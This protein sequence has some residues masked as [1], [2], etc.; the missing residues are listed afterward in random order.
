MTPGD[1][2]KDAAVLAE[3]KEWSAAA[4]ALLKSGDAIPV[5]DK[6]AFYLSR[7]KRYDEAIEVLR[8][9][10]N[11]QPHASRYRYTLGF[12]FAQREEWTQAIQEF[13]QA[14]RL[15]PEYL[16]AHYRLAQAYL[17]SGD[18]IRPRIAASRVLRIWHKL[19]PEGQERDAVKLARAS[20]M[21]GKLQ[22]RRGPDGAHHWSGQRP[23]P[24]TTRSTW[25]RRNSCAIGYAR[26]S[27]N[28]PPCPIRTAAPRGT[29]GPPRAAERV[30]RGHRSN[31]ARTR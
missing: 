21:L 18:E 12:Q 9:F 27:E 20:Y 26:S 22:L 28:S 6:F 4:D 2:L 31:A 24:A 14:V 11:R 8:A 19:D 3:R 7:A 1:A 17:R 25:M 30:E 15:A 29:G 13:E 23:K 10:C 5:P 16:K